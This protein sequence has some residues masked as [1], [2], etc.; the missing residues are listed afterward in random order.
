HPDERRMQYVLV[1]DQMEDLFDA[2]QQRS[3]REAFFNFLVELAKRNIWIIATCTTDAKRN[4][5]DYPALGTCFPEERRYELEVTHSDSSLQEII[6]APADAAGLTFEGDLETRIFSAALPG[7]RAVLPLLE[8]LL[9]ELY[10]T[11]CQKRNM[12]RLADYDRL[13]GINGV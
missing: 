9:T 6:R 8:L 10:L 13:K 11:R 2:P 3:T 12:L 7:K 5:V 4:F 1:V